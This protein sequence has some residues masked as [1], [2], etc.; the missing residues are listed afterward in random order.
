MEFDNEEDSLVL[1]KIVKLWITV[2]NVA[3]GGPSI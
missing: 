3:I 2:E 1:K